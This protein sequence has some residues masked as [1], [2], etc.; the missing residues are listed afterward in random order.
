MKVNHPEPDGIALLG[1]ERPNLF[2]G[3][4]VKMGKGDRRGFVEG[5]CLLVWPKSDIGHA[6]GRARS[7]QQQIRALLREVAPCAAP[8]YAR[9]VPCS[10]ANR[11]SAFLKDRCFEAME[12]YS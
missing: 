10:V 3:S 4:G 7:A 5:I 1:L 6:T 9:S 2:S 8:L 12:D 11:I